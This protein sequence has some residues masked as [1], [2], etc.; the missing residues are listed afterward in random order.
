MKEAAGVQ[1]LSCPRGLDV[2]PVFYVC[3]PLK[4][5]VA[6]SFMVLSVPL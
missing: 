1:V 4:K 2:K 5:E 3:F 6:L